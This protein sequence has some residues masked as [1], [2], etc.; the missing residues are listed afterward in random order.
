M[1]DRVSF[2]SVGVE[3]TCAQFLGESGMADVEGSLAPLPARASSETRVSLNSLWL[4][5][6]LF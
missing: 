6:T 5:G 3:G 1:S 2:V 4:R